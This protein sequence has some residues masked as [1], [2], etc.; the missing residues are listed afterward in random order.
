M[1]KNLLF[2]SYQDEDCDEGLSYA[3]DL[4]KMMNEDLAILLVNKKGLWQRFDNLMT[5]ITFAEANE[6][7]T[8]REILADDNAKD[9]HSKEKSASLIER[10]N[11]SDVNVSVRVTE[12]DVVSAVKGLL[13]QQAGIDMVLLSPSVTNNGNVS[14]KELNKLVKTASRPIVTMTKQALLPAHQ[15]C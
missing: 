11:K 1:R 8:A 14:A 15:S 5:A 7:D 10:C 6:H 3:I 12:T 4:A 13:A 2:V 9:E